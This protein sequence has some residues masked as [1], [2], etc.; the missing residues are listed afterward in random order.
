MADSRPVVLVIED[1][2]DIMA[3]LEQ[4]LGDAGHMVE[5]V[6]DGAA[7]LARIEAGGVD[8]VVLDLMLPRLNGLELCRRVRAQGGEVY[9]PIIMVTALADESQR[10][11]GF[12]AGADDYVC[13]PFSYQELLSRVH[14]WI[15]A[16]QR[17]RAAVEQLRRQEAALREAERLAL[18]ARLEGVAVTA[19]ELA[20]RIN[21]SLQAVL[22]ACDILA[23]DRR[24][25]AALGGVIADAQRGAAAAAAVIAQL[26]QV[27]RVETRST[28][29]GP[30]LDL[31]RSTQTEPEPP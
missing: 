26:Q 6:R 28:P 27:V 14:V 31:D 21:N 29:L 2:P 17:F 24:T 1:D 8:L 11:A 9:L 22:S 12:E 3:V 25:P 16:R 13:K 23:A 7:G 4:M 10:L 30:A 18:A 5:C 19:R 15:R 20:H